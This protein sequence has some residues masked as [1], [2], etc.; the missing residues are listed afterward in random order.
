MK[1]IFKYKYVFIIVLILGIGTVLAYSYNAS[2]VGYTPTDT[3]WNVEKVDDAIDYLYDKKLGFYDKEIYIRMSGW[4]SDYLKMTSSS[5]Y[6]SDGSYGYKVFDG[7]YA[8]HINTWVTSGVGGPHY[9]TFEFKKDIPTIYGFALYP[10]CNNLIT[11]LPRSIVIYTSTNGSTWNQVYSGQTDGYDYRWHFIMLGSAIKS[12][13]W[14]LQVN[15][16]WASD[17]ASGYASIGEMKIYG[18]K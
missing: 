12:K 2:D 16:T 3:E 7:S 17:T 1:N 5:N 6:S 14:K 11:R 8:A 18:Q 4:E 9:L 13:Y 10:Q 15:S